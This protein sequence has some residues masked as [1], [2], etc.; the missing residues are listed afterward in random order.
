MVNVEIKKSLTKETKNYKEAF[1]LK[2][3]KFFIKKKFEDVINTVAYEGMKGG[4][5]KAGATTKSNLTMYMT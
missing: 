4:N 3:Y 2:F 5:C 1:F